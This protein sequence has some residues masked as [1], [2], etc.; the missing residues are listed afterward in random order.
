M[1]RGKQ[2][3]IENL[4]DKIVYKALNDEDDI[5]ENKENYK[6]LYKVNN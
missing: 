3:R 6:R 5:F 2:E 4:N 1:K